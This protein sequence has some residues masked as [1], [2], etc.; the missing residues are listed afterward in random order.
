M[1]S[2][3]P[4]RAD[5]DRLRV[6]GPKAGS[7]AIPTPKMTQKGCGFKVELSTGFARQLIHNLLD[8]VLG[9]WII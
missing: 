8:S 6:G 7:D 9:V 2:A 4:G 1:L 5:E 3:Q